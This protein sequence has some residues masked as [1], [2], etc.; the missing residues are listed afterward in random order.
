MHS[1]YSYY[2]QRLHGDTSRQHN[3]AT[4][5][6]NLSKTYM[7]S[8]CIDEV[9][10][11]CIV[12]G[13]L[14]G[15]SAALYLQSHGYQVLLLDAD[16][17]GGKYSASSLNGG[18]V[19][20]NYQ[21]GIEYLSKQYGDN[22]AMQMWQISV[23]AVNLVRDNIKKYQIECD[24]QE[25]VM[26]VAYHR[27]HVAK[28]E[29]EYNLLSQQYAYSSLKILDAREIRDFFNTEH[30][31][32]GGLYYEDSLHINPASYLLGLAEECIK[33]G[34]K[35]CEYT[36]VTKVFD[37]NNQVMLHANIYS[38]H[39]ISYTQYVNNPITINSKFAILASNANNYLLHD[40]CD[41]SYVNIYPSMVVTEPLFPV[42]NQATQNNDSSFYTHT[43]NHNLKLM[44]KSYAIFD[45]RNVMDFYR[46]TG[47]NRLLFGGADAA[48]WPSKKEIIQNLE[49]KIISIFPQLYGIK[50][51]YA[52]A[53]EESISI[54]YAPMVNKINDKIF[55]SH[56]LSGHGL[57]LS[58][59]I[60][61]IL[62]EAINHQVSKFDL[63]SRVKHSKIISNVL[64]MPIIR[65]SSIALASMYY[66]L[67]DRIK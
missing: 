63:F 58:G 41:S 64:K 49:A 55:Y 12:G 14:T 59:M 54:N 67:I 32:Y 35:I 2:Y 56:G 39:N 52:W 10:D 16:I 33:L 23:D 62:G 19:S 5:H 46:I 44:K 17:I 13:G 25:G 27:S 40:K 57:A 45:T 38:Q 34:V 18:Q 37:Q 29:H 22:Y 21:C 48:N 43:N 15:M 47:D 66:K 42:E 20:P 60:G 3:S 24:Q 7:L 53:G 65:Q 50:F 4:Y 9:F 1:Q 6:S 11:V 36:K 8:E 28:L 51:E 31:Y 26:A 30:Q 61:N